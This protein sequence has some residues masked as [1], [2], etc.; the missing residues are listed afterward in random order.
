MPLVAPRRAISDPTVPTEMN[1]VTRKLLHC[2][3]KLRISITPPNS[4]SE[5][6]VAIQRSLACLKT[7]P[8]I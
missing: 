8:S 6:P 4:P 2:L 7:P 5:L 3:D 1:A